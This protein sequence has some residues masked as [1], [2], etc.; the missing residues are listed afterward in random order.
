M[1]VSAGHAKK[2]LDRD[3]SA[4]ERVLGGWHLHTPLSGPRR[5][6]RDSLCGLVAGT[7]YLSPQAEADL[8]RIDKN[9]FA[10]IRRALAGLA[11][12]GV[13]EEASPVVL[14]GAWKLLAV[15]DHYHVTFRRRE[16]DIEVARILTWT[17]LISGADLPELH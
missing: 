6:P 2:L 1:L 9:D 17:D 3:L 15:G 16:G 5:L 12:E 11:A 13:G 10:A 8:A 14:G 7:Y 4:P